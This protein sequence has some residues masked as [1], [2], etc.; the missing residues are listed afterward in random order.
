MTIIMLRVQTCLLSLTICT[1]IHICKLQ[2]NNEKLIN[3]ICFCK[4]CTNTIL[5]TN[6]LL[7]QSI[8]QI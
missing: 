7:Q 3:M 1:Y 4:Q 8:Q 5:K 6:G 2:L